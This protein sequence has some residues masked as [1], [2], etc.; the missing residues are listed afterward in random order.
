MKK[1]A[2][3]VDRQTVEILTFEDD[4]QNLSAEFALEREERK[5]DFVYKADE[6]FIKIDHRGYLG[7][8][9]SSG[10]IVLPIE[11]EFV[12]I[13]PHVIVTQKA[14]TVIFYRHNSEVWELEHPYCLKGMDYVSGCAV[15]EQRRNSKVRAIY[16]FAKGEFL[17][18]WA[19]HSRLVGRHWFFEDNSGE[20]KFV[21]AENELS[22][23][24]PAEEIC[25]FSYA[26]MVKIDGE[27]KLYLP[28]GV[29]NNLGDK[30]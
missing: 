30:L 4:A 25:H 24:W 8:M 19:K 12:R 27:Y 10:E 9:N 14:G 23:F 13:T 11:F 29:I 15:L 26:T 22:K 18:G 7:V 20:Q 1:I 21:C 28:S 17:I 6:G 5:F 2:R 16:S 3:I